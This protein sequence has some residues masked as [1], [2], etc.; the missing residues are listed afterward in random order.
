VLT[1]ILT[2]KAKIG[3][4]RV[5]VIPK[6]IAEALNISEGSVVKMTV[7]NDRLIIEP[8][9]DAIWLS[10]YGEKIAKITLRELEEISVEEQKKVIE[11]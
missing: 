1:V 4:K 2:S 3:K 11:K 10:L 9:R 7:D 5:L 6:K 8:I